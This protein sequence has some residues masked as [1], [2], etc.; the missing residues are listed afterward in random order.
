MGLGMHLN[1]SGIRPSE[2]V[3]GFELGAYLETYA[4]LAFLKC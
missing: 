1:R 4:G 2:A 3:Q